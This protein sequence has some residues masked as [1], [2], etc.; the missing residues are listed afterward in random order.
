MTRGRQLRLDWSEHEGRAC[1]RVRGW[2]EAELREPDAFAR[3]VARLAV[4]PSGLVEAGADLRGLQPVA[5]RF[6][7]HGDAV[8]FIPRFPFL[9]G[10]GYSLLLLPA[11]GDERGNTGTW[12]IQRPARAGAPE[13]SVVA[14]YPT[15]DGLPVNQLKLY[16][17]FSH[18]MSEG[19]AARAIHVRRADTHQPLADV[20][21]GMAPE[22]WDQERRR[23]T[24]LLDPGRIKRGLVP[25]QEAGY[26]LT[27]GVPVVVTIDTSFRDA[28]G[29][30]LRNGAE[31]R[32]EVG[33]PLRVRIDPAKWRL[34]EPAIGSA[35]PLSVEF[36]RPLD[37]ALLQHCLWVNDPAGMPL[38]GHGAVGP[39][40][41]AWRFQPQS[42]WKQ[43]RYVVMVDPR[44]ED[45]AGN[46]LVRVFDRDLTRAEDAPADARHVAMDF[47]LR[48]AHSPF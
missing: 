44:L 32:Y 45:L 23:L 5:G 24:L 6:A 28:A 12:T 29:R 41:R 14:I 37:S 43:G 38:G 47:T 10:A 22:L 9:D 19:W 16:V 26:P 33:P 2:T 40:E 15:A 31:R 17:H 8:C 34:H 42:P 7:L 36:D 11:P 46:S 27:E 35:D 13:T 21:L 48:A 30:P 20:F 18:S 1:L 4:L 25:N 3:L 39:G